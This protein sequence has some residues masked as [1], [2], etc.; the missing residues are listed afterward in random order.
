MKILLFLISVVLI[1]IYA[2]GW[3]KVVLLVLG[4]LIFLILL[5]WALQDPMSDT[6][7]YYEDI[8]WVDGGDDK[9]IENDEKASEND[10]P[11]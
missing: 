3:V 10:E 11:K 5:Y 6:P 1:F 8:D 9:P 7:P 4:L 2:A